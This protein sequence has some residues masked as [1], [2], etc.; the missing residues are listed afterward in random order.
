MTLQVRPGFAIDEM[1][2]FSVNHASKRARY[3]LRVSENASPGDAETGTRAG[4]TNLVRRMREHAAERPGETAFVHLIDGDTPQASM[5]FAQLDRRARAIA[6][7]LQDMRLAGRNVVLAYPPGLDFIAAF[8]G[9]LYAGCV[10]VPAYPPRPRTLDRP[11]Y[12]AA[13]RSGARHRRSPQCMKT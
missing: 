7:Y 3:P 2:S 5:T 6:A 9:A 11:H 13:R 10:A 4:R 12:G 1:R 8:F